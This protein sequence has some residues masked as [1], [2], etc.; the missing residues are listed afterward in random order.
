MDF[1]GQHLEECGLA[2]AVR[3]DDAA[4]LAALDGKIDVA[5]GE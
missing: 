1:A 3:P 4:P 5:V 2:G